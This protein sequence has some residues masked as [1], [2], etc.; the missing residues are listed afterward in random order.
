[1]K[2]KFYSLICVFKLCDVTVNVLLIHVNIY[3]NFIC[4]TQKAVTL[5]YFDLRGGG[6]KCTVASGALMKIIYSPSEF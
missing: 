4:W 2:H 5:K 6:G 1:M 3:I